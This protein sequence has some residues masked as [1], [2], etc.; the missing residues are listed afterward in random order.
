MCKRPQEV[1]KTGDHVGEGPS[2]AGVNN[3]HYS[4]GF[5]DA[6]RNELIVSAYF[7]VDSDRRGAIFAID[8]DSGN[9]R[10]ISGDWPTDEGK[11]G[12]K[13]EG[14]AFAHLLDVRADPN[15][16]GFVY[17]FSDPKDPTSHEIFRVNRDTGARE[18]IWKS[19]DTRFGQ[20]KSSGGVIVQT[21]DTGF[22][23]DVNGFLVGIANPQTGRGV[24]RISLDGKECIPISITSTDKSLDRGAGVEIRGF[25]QGYTIKEGKLIAFTTQ[26]KQMLEIDL[27]TGDREAIASAGSAGVMGERWAVWDDSHS[28]WWTAG[29]MNSVTIAAV[30][31]VSKTIMN[32]AKATGKEFDWAP[33]GAG[34]PIRINSLNYGGIWKHP[35]KD[36]LLVAQDSVS[37][38]T[39]EIATGNSVILSL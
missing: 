20:L 5:V 10:I 15:D 34:G 12:T 31:P 13:G 38:V 7:G 17:A 27:S 25:L 6:D 8:V 3:A 1:A 9:R 37:I 4:G 29:L 33:L 14:P 22:A 26:P 36:F 30:D 35:S 24:M 16:P 32:I 11:I 18:M 21:H 28:V 39:Y 23:V 2:L 19:R